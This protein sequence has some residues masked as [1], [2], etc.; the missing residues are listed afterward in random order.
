MIG[1]KDDPSAEA[2]A[3]VYYPGAA[4]ESDNVRERRPESQDEDIVLLEVAQV[5]DN[6]DPDKHG[7]QAQEDAAHVVTSENLG[8]YGYFENRADDGQC[9]ADDD[10]N[11]PAIDKLQAV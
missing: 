6:S 3:Q 4:D 8:L 11:V 9:I 10:Q 2:V 5:A 7:A 1:P